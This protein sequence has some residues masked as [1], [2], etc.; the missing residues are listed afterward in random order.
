MPAHPLFSALALFA[1]LLLP[2]S[3]DAQPMRPR[4]GR[5]PMAA[6]AGDANELLARARSQTPQRVAAAERLGAKV[7]NTS[8]GRSFGLIWQSAGKPP[9]GWIVSLH[10]SASWAYDEIVLWQP[11]AER[12]NLGIVALQWWFGGGQRTEDYYQPRELRR[13]LEHLMRRAGATRENALLHGFS[14]GSANLYALVAFDA[15][16]PNPLFRSAIANA[17]GMSADF[18]PN[19]EIDSGRLGAAPYAGTHWWLY[20]GGG[21]PNPD[22]DGCPAMRRTRDWLAQRGADAQITEDASGNHGG[23]HRNP[24]NVEQ[25]LDWFLKTRPR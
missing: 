19:R 23:F 6:P 22:R 18:P 15:Q 3:A 21:D 8:D 9:V 25:A 20:C 5:P 10:G 2:A 4:D 12:N 1:A 13:E 16:L 24:R 7:M 11:F 17:G 14:R